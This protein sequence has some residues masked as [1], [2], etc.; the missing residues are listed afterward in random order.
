MKPARTRGGRAWLLGL[1][2]A[3]MLAAGSSG[4]EPAGASDDPCEGLEI[5][6]EY[7]SQKLSICIRVATCSPT[8]VSAEGYPACVVMDS[9]MATWAG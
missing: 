8:A 6:V 3:L 4:A 1:A 9:R 7:C 5:C 2:L